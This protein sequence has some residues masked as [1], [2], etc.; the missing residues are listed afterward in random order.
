MSESSS[1]IDGALLAYLR[2]AFHGPELAFRS[3]PAAITGGYD[4]RIFAFQL[5]DAPEAFSGRLV[6]RIFQTASE[7]SRAA[8]EAAVQNALAAAGYPVPVVLNV[9]TDH[10]VLGGAFTIMPFVPGRTL[11]SDTVALARHG[12]RLLANAHLQLHAIDAGPVLD[13]LEASGAVLPPMTLDALLSSL[14]ASTETPGLEGLLEGLG[15]LETHR[16]RDPAVPSVL[17]LDFHPGNI[18]IQCNRVTGV[19]DWPN[20]GLGDP[21]ADVATTRVLLTAGPLDVLGWARPPV[22]AL[23]KWLAYRYTRAYRKRHPLPRASLRYYEALRCFMA[24][25]HA[26]EI[27]VAV[28]AG[29]EGQSHGYAWGAPDQVRRMTALF[30]RA[31]GVALRLPPPN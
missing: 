13:R 2:K 9:C 8:L 20:V 28:R 10:S 31:T 1:P 11:L 21:A 16:P 22:N 26:S 5:D 17:H 7:A 4:T 15:W 14:R 27:R 25:L 6:I 30:N 23:R 12:S 3:A 24:M 18:L 19:I 29:G